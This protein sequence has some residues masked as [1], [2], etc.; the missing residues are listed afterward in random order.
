[1]KRVFCCLAIVLFASCSYRSSSVRLQGDPVSIAWLAG[2]WQGEFEGASSGRR[3]S[4]SFYL[5]S[6]TDSLVGDVMMVDPAGNVI[7]AADRADV[8][9]LHVRN[10]QLLSIDVVVVHADAIRGVLEPYIAPDCSCV[11][12]TTFIGRVLGDEITGTFETRGSSGYRAEGVWRMTRTGS[13]R[14]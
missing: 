9:R 12:S 13:T 1:M 10:N 14:P 8:H 11:V 2:T 7:H 4:L 5:P 3:G 6:G